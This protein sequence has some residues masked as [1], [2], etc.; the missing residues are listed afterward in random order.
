MDLVLFDVGDIKAALERLGDELRRR[1]LVTYV[2]VIAKARVPIV[3][4]TDRDTGIKVDICCEQAGGITAAELILDKQRVI[5]ALRP[6]TL[7]LKYFLHCRGLNDTF[8]G[9]LHYTI[10]YQEPVCD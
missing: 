1:D 4:F 8:T 10:P 5:P 3:K 7:V 6:L 9:I 2:E